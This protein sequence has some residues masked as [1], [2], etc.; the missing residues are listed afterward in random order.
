[1]IFI[2]MIMMIPSGP[3]DNNDD[4]SDDDDDNEYDDDNLISISTR[5]QQQ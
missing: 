2:K 1:M 3:N 5:P 4:E